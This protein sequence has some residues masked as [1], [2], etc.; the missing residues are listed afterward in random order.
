M[1]LCIAALCGCTPKTTDKQSGMDAAATTEKYETFTGKA[2]LKAVH[3]TV[4]DPQNTRGLATDKIAHSFG[5]AS[6]GE[7]HE[8][9]K[10]SQKYFDDNKV[11]AIT[12]D[13]RGEKVLYL[14][15]DCGYENGNTEIILDVLKE[16]KVKAAFFCTLINIK[17]NP[18]L[19]VRI[20]NDGHILGNHSANHP[21]F[22][23]ISREKMAKE[24]EDCDNY[25]RENFGYTSPYFRFP[26]GEYSENALELVNS[27]GYKC[28]FWS[29]AYND[30]NTDQQKGGDYAFET[31]TSRLHPGAIILL[32]SVSADNAQAMGR[33]ID[34]ARGQGYE[35]RTLNDL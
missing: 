10:Q 27:I 8:I 4:S 20:I 16:K 28:V 34:Y 32:H 9:A 22:D 13:T 29:L 3:F 6:N 24:I 15:F 26:K 11:N 2:P 1:S 18:E 21:C 31:V 7:P 25:L 14:T 12:Y 19:M 17:S 35:F 30:W 5:V 23:E 33:I